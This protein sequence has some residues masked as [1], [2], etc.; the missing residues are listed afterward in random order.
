MK[1]QISNLLRA[2]YAC[3][4]IQDIIS[5]PVLSKLNPA[6]FAR[7]YFDIVLC[8]TGKNGVQVSNCGKF[9]LRLFEDVKER[10]GCDVTTAGLANTRK[11]LLGVICR[12]KTTSGKEYVPSV[13]YQTMIVQYVGADSWQQLCDDCDDMLCE[14]EE[15]L[16]DVANGQCQPSLSNIILEPKSVC[17]NSLISIRF[18]SGASLTLQAIGHSN[19]TVTETIDT[20]LNIHDT[21]LIIDHIIIGNRLCATVSSTR[22][23]RYDDTWLSPC[24]RSFKEKKG[25]ILLIA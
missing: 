2:Q 21:L 10:T 16:S 5:N 19:F 25:S 7:E 3:N 20:G 22:H 8:R 12:Y 1:K 18:A 9:A 6:D 23:K 15:F 4:M 17:H 13:V 14:L 11:Q 24:I